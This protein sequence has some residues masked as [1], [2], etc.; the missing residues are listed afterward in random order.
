MPFLVKKAENTVGR[1][2]NIR[3]FAGLKNP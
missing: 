3:V 1:L 2:K